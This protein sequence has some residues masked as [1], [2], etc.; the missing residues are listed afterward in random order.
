M[1]N[2]ITFIISGF[3][4]IGSTQL[5]AQEEDQGSRPVRDPFESAVLID[6]QTVIVPT[7][8]TLE[9]DMVHRFG[10]VEN[11]ISDFFGMYAPGA[12]IRLGLT[13]SVIENLSVGVGFTK[14]NK[15]VDFNAKYAIL[16]QTRD[17]STPVNLTFFGNIAID[18]REEAVFEKDLHRLSSFAEMIIATRFT[19][20]LSVQVTPSFS[21]FNA[22]DSAMSNDIIGVGISGRYKI[23]A[24]SAVIFDFNQPVTTHDDIVD[25]KPNVGIG[26]EVSTSSHAFQMFVSTFQGILP[27]HNMVFSENEF[28]KGGILL[29]F[30]ITR[31]WNF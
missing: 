12:N 7:A 22:V 27:Q 18:T 20:N 4:F 13:Y 31:L 25:V 30:N 29:G 24:Q 14:L 5:I 23:S 3:F 15:Y 17:W 21:H 6:N 28:N 16:K 19:P 8:K 9:F 2:L 1:K 11:G 26:V 10:V